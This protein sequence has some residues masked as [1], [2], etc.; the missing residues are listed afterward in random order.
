M[1]K[2]G[3]GQEANIACGILGECM[4]DKAQVHGRHEIRGVWSEFSVM[5]FILYLCKCWLC[6]IFLIST[7]L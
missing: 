2:E 4:G 1:E 3:C 6:T 5:N 7:L